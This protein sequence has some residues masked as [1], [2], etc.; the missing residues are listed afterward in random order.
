VPKVSA[1]LDGRGFA[2]LAIDSSTDGKQ[3]AHFG[4]RG[5]D[6]ALVKRLQ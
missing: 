6:Y 5:E 1:K 4:S 2:A 3:S